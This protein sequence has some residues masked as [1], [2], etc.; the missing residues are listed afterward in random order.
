VAPDERPPLPPPSGSPIGHL[1]DDAAELGLSDDQLARLKQ[2]D[3]ELGA[4][5]AEHE[6][7]LRSWEPV[8]PTK[9]DAPRGLGFHASGGQATLDQYGTPIG[10]FPA[11]GGAAGFADG[12]P[13]KQLVIRGETIERVHRDRARDTR[14]AIRSALAVLDAV[15]RVIALRV[16]RDHG[17]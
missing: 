2:I 8:A 13:P 16:L 6:T 9:P 11:H 10:G 14:D 15:Q 12:D 7:E 1:V 4:K 17:V 5:L 3:G